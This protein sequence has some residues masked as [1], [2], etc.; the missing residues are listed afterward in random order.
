MPDELVGDLLGASMDANGYT[1]GNLR[2]PEA[3]QEVATKQYVDD[4]SGGGGGGATGPTGPTGAT[5]ATGA[6]GVTGATGPSGASGAPGGGGGSAVRGTFANL[7]DVTSPVIG[8][9]AYWFRPGN[10]ELQQAAVGPWL[11]EY[12]VV[13]EY[14]PP[15]YGLWEYRSGPAT[16]WKTKGLAYGENLQIIEQQWLNQPPA[17]YLPGGGVQQQWMVEFGFTGGDATEQMEMRPV[18]NPLISYQW[19]RTFPH[20]TFQEDQQEG[21]GAFAAPTGS[22]TGV[23]SVE[24]AQII[25]LFNGMASIEDATEYTFSI[26]PAPQNNY[27]A[28]FIHPWLSVRPMAVL[29]A[30]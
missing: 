18:T 22:S 2:D 5:G 28:N 7:E 4:N 29:V 10:G 15:G 26:D 11:M 13:P 30:L 14:F 1:V 23:N 12:V 6:T 16:L 21:I 20:A 17:L 9:K 24:V 3:P 19:W 25:M 27:P 8:D